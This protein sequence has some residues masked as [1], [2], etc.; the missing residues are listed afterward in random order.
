VGG[1]V[2]AGLWQ[3]DVNHV[4]ELLLRVIG[5]PDYGCVAFD[6]HPFVVLAIVQIFRDVGHDAPIKIWIFDC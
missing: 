6:T 1:K 3:F 5:D 4:S 2:F